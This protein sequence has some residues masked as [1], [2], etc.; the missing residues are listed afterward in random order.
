MR[1]EQSFPVAR[2]KLF[3]FLAV[4]LHSLK[5]LS[6][7]TK[8]RKAIESGFYQPQTTLCFFAFQTTP[9]RKNKENK[10]ETWHRGSGVAS[11]S[12]W[13]RAIFQFD[14]RIRGCLGDEKPRM[15]TG[16]K[17]GTGDPKGTPQEPF[18]GSEAF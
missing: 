1:V 5:S 2:T 12:G 9:P 15:V 13:S 7:P 10:H 6:I 17:D 4:L 8:Q 14:H 3:L 18:G 11:R 16:K